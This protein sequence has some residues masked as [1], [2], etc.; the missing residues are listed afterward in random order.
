MGLST[1]Q[2]GTD[3]ETD[4]YL[5][6]TDENI[7][8]VVERGQQ[9]TPASDLPPQ[10]SLTDLRN[11]DETQNRSQRF[12]G[13]VGTDHGS[14]AEFFQ[15]ARDA[16]WNLVDSIGRFAESKKWSP[17]QKEDYAW[18]IDK[19]TNAEMGGI[20]EWGQFGIDAAQAM[21]SDATLWASVL[22]TPFTGGGSLA[23]RAAA[24]KAAQTG[25]T[26]MINQ[27]V[28]QK[29]TGAISKVAPKVW[30]KPQAYGL[31]SAEG[32]TI[33]GGHD[34][35]RQM[36]ELET[37]VKDKWSPLSTAL[38][39]PA[40]AILA[41]AALWGIDKASAKISNALSKRA[42]RKETELADSLGEQEYIKLKQQ[43]L[44]DNQEIS[45]DRFD[46]NTTIPEWDNFN[47]VQSAV[48]KA[49][50]MLIAKPATYF[51]E[52]AYK[53][54]TL[55][56]LLPLIRHDALKTFGFGKKGKIGKE[57]EGRY[58]F[59]EEFGDLKGHYNSRLEEAIDPLST[60]GGIN[61]G[62][63]Y[64]LD[65]NDP[66]N[67]EVIRLV[68]DS[69][70]VI[71]E[72]LPLAQ[73]QQIAKSA[74]QVRK[75][76][77]DIKKDAK[78]VG[79]EINEVE[80]F[81]PR[82]WDR[83]AIK[84][85]RGEMIGLLIESGEVKAKIDSGHVDYLGKTDE[86][87]ADVIIK[88]M[89]DV[90]ENLSK[91]E[92]SIMGDRTLSLLNDNAFEKFMS[93]D[94][95]TTVQD[96]IISATM[97]IQRQKSYGL[98]WK[99]L[100]PVAMKEARRYF[101]T[102]GMEFTGDF[103]DQVIYRWI[104]PIEEE[105]AVVGKTLSKD[106]KTRLLTLIGHQTN[107][108]M[109]DIPNLR[110]ESSVV[111]N[112][113][114][115]GLLVQQMNKLTE[116]T[117]TSIAEPVISISTAGFRETGIGL[118]KGFR[119]QF[120]KRFGFS[121]TEMADVAIGEGVDFGVKKLS[122]EEQGLQK[123]ALEM[124]GIDEKALIAFR[125]ESLNAAEE[126]YAKLKAQGGDVRELQEFGIALELALAEQIEGLYGEGMTKIPR[127]ITQVYFKAIMLDAWTRTS[128]VAAYI[129]GKRY[130]TNIGKQLSTGKF[131]KF[132]AKIV[133]KKNAIARLEE[134]ARRLGLNPD[135]LVTW[136]NNGA[137][138]NDPFFR[139]VKRGAVRYQGEIIM[140]PA[141]V[142][143]QK[144][145]VYGG[146]GT[147]LIFQLGSFPVAFSNTALKNM[148]RQ[149]IRY[150]VQNGAPVMGTAATLL[151]F[152]DLI[153]MIKSGGTHKDLPLEERLSKNIERVGLSTQAG[154]QFL[155]G[156]KAYEYNDNLFVSFVKGIGGPFTAEAIDAIQYGTG[157]REIGL[158]NMPGW[159]TYKKLDPE[160]AER[161]LAA[162]RE[163]DKERGVIFKGKEEREQRA[164]GGEISEDYPVK[165]VSNNPAD[166]KLDN[167]PISFNE[168]AANKE[169]PYPTYK[170]EMERLG[171]KSG[172]IVE[173][174]LEYFNPGNLEQ[175][176]QGYAGD[177]G[178]T[179]ANHRG[180]E[181]TKDEKGNEI[182]DGRKPFIIFDSPEAGLRA[183][184]RDYMAKFKRYADDKEFGI[185]Y[186]ILEYLGGGREGTYEERLKRAGIDNEDPQGYVTRI[187][188]QYLTDQAE[189]LD[190][191]DGL[192]QRTIIE[193]NRETEDMN[194]QQRIA[195]RNRI[196]T[197]T[198]PEIFE[199]SKQIAQYSYPTGTT[200]EQMRED[201]ETGAYRTQ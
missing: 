18:L 34:I 183:L 96:Y 62:Y 75:I 200:S 31:A 81:F 1:T 60:R 40:G 160:T 184:R 117:L 179:Y 4:T 28:A 186:A 164:L 91:A 102:R 113:I 70:Y 88:R 25:L 42:A 159:H 106:E 147:K 57:Y 84:N 119:T 76:F 73:R 153:N 11:H 172:N 107:T 52:M 15:Y 189:G 176:G 2:R 198:N 115:G 135:E 125:N 194:E 58:D 167:L 8:S 48:E 141:T 124:G 161:L 5:P 39:I 136:Y 54:E 199:R 156:E 79:I 133:P 145:L 139:N 195:A 16:D 99:T 152:G 21:G 29:V 151:V 69:A 30:S 13:S 134:E 95:K 127:K 128:Q 140:N 78:D 177:T 68:R 22:L 181:H 74:G 51:K 149:W 24:G 10:Y 201:L 63:K 72:T 47:A 178:K 35:T 154:E 163:L 50:S 173:E 192:V 17:Q 175:R 137:D 59:A 83:K 162:A 97:K 105:L 143:S 120:E 182:T 53:S 61:K 9:Q 104:R 126:V 144:P 122:K 20:K 19:F 44:V 98:D 55:Q 14:V 80:D 92:G 37:G 116:A 32:A 197:Y 166:R 23:T 65:V 193:E 171:F 36:T 103:Q 90:E 82:I 174:A 142:A 56:K 138:I 114:S 111:N 85:N 148:A 49:T 121:P 188:E 86:Q 157:G 158:T 67:L 38:A 190:G 77:D 168:V 109:R 112:L 3:Q 27:N 12:M 187:K 170:D 41:P 101:K 131:D 165:A 45:L 129:T 118:A 132:G 33:A 169:N 108:N 43:E 155:R 185:D 94:I 66:L 110:F 123:I 64:A 6:S 146:K 180:T 196:E 46:K 130:I 71:D 93:R 87:V 191:L 100:N 150:P 7:K 26:R 89:L